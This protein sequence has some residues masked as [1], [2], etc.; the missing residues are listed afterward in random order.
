[1][2]DQLGTPARVK[3]AYDL[4]SRNEAQY[5]LNATDRERFKSRIYSIQTAMKR[6]Q[7]SYAQYLARGQDQPKDGPS[8]K[9]DTLDHL[10]LV[11]EYGEMFLNLAEYGNHFSHWQNYS[12][13][14]FGFLLD[15][16]GMVR[17][18]SA[19]SAVSGLPPPGPPSS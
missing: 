2:I 18:A 12:L 13:A 8:K 14:W 16:Y 15:T 11:P 3:A 9:K 5:Q 10:F 17:V 4:L 1:M 7:L 19:R 6:D